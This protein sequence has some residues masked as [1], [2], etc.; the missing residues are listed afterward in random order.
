MERLDFDVLIKQVEGLGTTAQAT[1][2]YRLSRALGPAVLRSSIRYSFQQ[3]DRINAQL[4]DGHPY[5]ERYK[6]YKYLQEN[7]GIVIEEPRPWRGRLDLEGNKIFGN[8][9]KDQTHQ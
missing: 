9:R 5:K 3:L 8:D 2:M 6:S 1:L 4:P 7:T